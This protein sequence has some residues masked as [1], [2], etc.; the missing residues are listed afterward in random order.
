MEI[1]AAREVRTTCPYCGVGC[2]VLAKI[3]ADGQVSVRGDPDHPANFG[4]LCSKGSALAETI[5]LD[6]RLLHPEVYGRRAGWDE[7]LDRVASTFSQTIAEHGPDSVAFYVS[8]QLLTEDYYVANKLMKGFVG[9]ANIDTNSRLCMASSVAGHRRAFGS[10]TVPGTYEDLELADLIVLVGSNLAWCHPVLYQRI[11]AAREKRPE[12]K[13]VL[14]DPRRTMTADIADLHLAIAPD[15]D[16]ALFTGLLAYLGQHNALDRA[17]IAEHTTGFGQALFAA[18]KLDLAGIAEATSLSEDELGRFYGLFARTEKTVTVYSQGV[19]QSSSGTDKVNAII[20][21]HLATGRIGK[22]G[23]GPFSVTGQP[24]AMGGREVGGMANMLVAHMEIENPAHRARVR[25]FWNAPSMADKP[26]LKAVDMFKAV[27]DGRIKALWIMATNPVDSMPDADAVEAAIKA[28]PFV[29]VSDVLASTDT[30]RHAHVRL[31][32]TAW[33]E[34]DGTVTNSE[35]RI[36]RQ[37]AFL[38]TPGEARPDWWIIAEVGKR[39]GFGEAFSDASPAEIFAEHAALSA[40]E[41]DGARDFDIGAYAGVDV[42]DYDG[43]APFQWPAPSQSPPTTT[44]FFANGNFYTPDGKARF[45][46]IR[47]ATDTRTDEKFPLILNTGRV[48]DHWHTMTRTGKSP[49]LSQHIA[50]PFVEIHPADAQRFGIGDADIVRISSPRGEVLVRALVTLRQRQGS[51]FAPMHW[52][53]QFAAKGRLDALT[54]SLTDPVSGQPAL[55]HVAVRIEKFAAKAFGFAVTRE[56]PASVTAT[57]W[58]VAKCRGGWR[59][60]LA[61]ADDNTD[62][63]GFAASLFGAPPTSDTLAYHDRDA[64]QH[65]IAAF[66]AERLQGALFV[67]PGPVAVSRGWAAEQLE[68]TH[69][70]QRERFRIVAGR[71]GAERPDAGATVCSCFSI[72]ANQIAAAVA[73]GCT[74]VASIGET[75]K[76]GTNCGSCRAEIRVI[77]E[78]RRVQAAE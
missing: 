15:G 76:A 14:I 35:R 58:A 22:P 16:V 36:S 65:R 20:N 73:A 60:E 56:R 78:A 30:V 23:A 42:E 37:R 9:S 38:P 17:Y 57:Y 26:G 48:R 18:S 43:L 44:R 53:D 61:F 21:C 5:D 3:A 34:K 31:P 52:T 4:R 45:I 46:P 71:A 8:G 32:A 66:D 2:G 13:I 12:M 6:G 50:E 29:V 47:P 64:G 67:A 33:G 39:M 25:R 1:D 55:K 19:N 7:A 51:L 59:V 10:D 75:L 24:N 27:G 54:A 77:I 74:T 11:A 62:W 70:G 41:N 40:Y 63:A 49:R 69:A 28:C 72:G 68:E